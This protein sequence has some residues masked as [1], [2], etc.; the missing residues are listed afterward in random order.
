MSSNINY[1]IDD[2]KIHNQNFAC[3]S[4]ITPY[5]LKG[6]SKYLIKCR[7]VYGN[8]IRTE[9][10]CKKLN[11][12][13]PSFDVYKVSVGEWIAWKDNCDV[14]ED[15]RNELNELMMNYN[16]ERD[17]SKTLHEK[18]KEQLKTGKL[19]NEDFNKNNVEDIK[20]DET[21]EEISLENH[22]KISYLK[23]DDEINGQLFYCISFLTPEQLENNEIEKKFNV[24]GFKIR[25]MFSNE[26]SAK[27]HCRKL[28][29][30]DHS[31]NIYIAKMGHWVSWS[32]N[33]ENAEDF[34][35]SNKD[36]NNLMK[37]H[38]ENQEKAA[39]FNNEQKQKM[40][41]ES[42]VSLKRNDNVSN[43]VNEIIEDTC[44]EDIN[45]NELL[46]DEDNLDDINKELNEAR[47]MYEKLLKEEKKKK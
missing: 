15:P 27:E 18:R 20:N 29:K 25:G 35:Y 32:D 17:E 2:E 10:E 36:L 14:N 39:Q 9:D 8:E 6:C 47:K 23:E 42:L 45:L 19:I 33:T 30:L 3:I 28:H 43:I 5:K 7:G 12:K 22:K 44:D 37:A 16:K 21:K 40:M 46:N 1:L 34:E 38:K 31:H 41:N 24:R 4:I 11:K 13:D 26:E